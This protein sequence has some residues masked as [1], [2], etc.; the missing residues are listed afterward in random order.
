MHGFL[1]FLL[2]H[3]LRE[4]P[5]SDM[6]DEPQPEVFYPLCREPCDGFVYVKCEA[7]WLVGS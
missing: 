1:W 3:W 2:Y 7:F 6:K 4:Y 5:E